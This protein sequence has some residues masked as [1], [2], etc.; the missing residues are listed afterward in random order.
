MEENKKK[1][2][3][4][5]FGEIN[6]MLL[7][8]SLIFG[9]LI[10]LIYIINYV[11][12]LSDIN[13]VSQILSLLIALTAVFL[14][15][16]ILFFIILILSPL[17]IL[18]A[19]QIDKEINIDEGYI[20]WNYLIA[21]IM[22]FIVLSLSIA[23]PYYSEKIALT[24]LLVILPL[25]PILSYFLEKRKFKIV[26]KKD[27]FVGLIQLLVFLFITVLFLLIYLPESQAN[28]FAYYQIIATWLIFALFVNILIV[29]L[30]SIEK[31]VNKI[32]LTIGVILFFLIV[33]SSIFK[34]A[35]K[36]NLFVVKPF[37]M[38]KIGHYKETLYFK[39]ENL[40]IYKK[41]LFNDTNISYAKFCVLSNIGSEFIVQKIIHKT[42]KNEKNEYIIKETCDNNRTYRIDKNNLGG[43]RYFDKVTNEQEVDKIDSNSTNKVKP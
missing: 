5:G 15:Y 3:P 38:L 29:K 7:N 13:S 4:D 39:K 41:E 20:V 25:C 42:I 18:I 40:Y 24:T 34:I 32:I 35:G 10:G 26:N 21:T 36:S 27:Y 6:K 33:S 12:A 43:F 1:Y 19:K 31:K 8:F 11:E 9:A 28:D 22:L 14:F 37:E 23:L 30:N 2:I 17:M 16:T